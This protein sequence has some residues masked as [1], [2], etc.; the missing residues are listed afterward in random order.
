MAD[1]SVRFIKSS[2]NPLTLRALI[3]RAGGEIIGADSY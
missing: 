3:T 1:G 2:I